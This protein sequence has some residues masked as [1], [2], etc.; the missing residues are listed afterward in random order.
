M[1]KEALEYLELIEESE[2]QESIS[3]DTNFV[4]IARLGSKN[5]KIVYASLNELK[6]IDFGAA[7]YCLIGLGNLHFVEE[8]ML[9]FWKLER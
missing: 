4:A 5:P 7:P 1:I 8:D 9:N 3:K 2:K 6:E